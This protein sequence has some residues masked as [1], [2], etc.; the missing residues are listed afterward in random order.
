[1]KSLAVLFLALAATVVGVLPAGLGHAQ[2]GLPS[3]ESTFLYVSAGKVRSFDAAA[4]ES[5]PEKRREL[6][7]QAIAEHNAHVLNV[8]LHRQM[9]PWAMRSSVSVVHRPDNVLSLQ[10]AKVGGAP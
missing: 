9:I 6:I 5:N 8:P 10:T 1:M 2:A 4:V 7:R 3:P